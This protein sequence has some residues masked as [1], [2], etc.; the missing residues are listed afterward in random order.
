MG[1]LLYWNRCKMIFGL[2]RARS[3]PCRIFLFIVSW[4]HSLHG[5][6]W[7]PSKPRT[8]HPKPELLGVQSPNENGKK[9]K[10]KKK[11]KVKILLFH[12]IFSYQIIEW[13]R[14]THFRPFSW[15]ISF[16]TCNSHVHACVYHIYTVCTP[17]IIRFFFQV[18]F[19]FYVNFLFIFF[20]FSLVLSH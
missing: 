16:N 9:G 3:G 2:R 12:F 20:G 15:N 8:P 13:F 6:D 17:Y 14:H 18:S 4:I 7:P 19:P 11:K 10:K 5:N 1:E